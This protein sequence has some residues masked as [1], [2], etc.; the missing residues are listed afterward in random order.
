MTDT[1]SLPLRVLFC[2]G[3][4]QNFFDLPREKIG[5]VCASLWRHAERRREHG[6]REGPGHHGRRQ[7]GRRSVRTGAPWTFY[8]MADVSDFDNRGS[9][10]QSL[11][12]DARSAEYNLWRYGKIEARIGRALKVPEPT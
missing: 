4:T 9:G 8:I 3:V 7:T 1:A 6:G 10:V 11:Q 2:C 12:N 5:A